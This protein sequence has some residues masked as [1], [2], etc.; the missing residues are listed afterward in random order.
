MA[1]GRFDKLVGKV[2]PGTYINFESGREN[3]VISNGTRGT[4]IV[5]LPKATYGPAKQFIKLTSD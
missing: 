3:A 2:R 4:V 5:P 1:G